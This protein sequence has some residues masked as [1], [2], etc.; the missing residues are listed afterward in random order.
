MKLRGRTLLIATTMM[1]GGCGSGDGVLEDRVYVPVV[2]RDEVVGSWV[3][4]SDAPTLLQSLL[5]AGRA[6]GPEA[7]AL[8]SGEDCEMTA[9]LARSLIRCELAYAAEG[10]A[11]GSCSW[12]VE[13][14]SEG[15]SVHVVFRG[16]D[17]KTWAARFGVFRHTTNRDIALLG[18]C[19]VGDAYGLFR[20]GGQGR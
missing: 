18:T 3:P 2:P 9:A 1:L 10:P 16:A 12:R 19:A 17:G 5:G 7:L 6:F 8:R 15:E 20:Q 13:R 14:S 11:K 4:H